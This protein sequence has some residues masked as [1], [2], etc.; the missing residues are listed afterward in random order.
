MA[1][2]RRRSSSSSSS[3]SVVSVLLLLSLVVVVVNAQSL[4]YLSNWSAFFSNSFWSQ[5]T[6]NQGR[7][8]AGGDVTLFNY[9]VGT[10]LNASDCQR[11]DLLVGGDLS[12]RDGSVPN[13]EV[14]VVGQSQ[15]ENV[16][17]ETGCNLASGNSPIDFEAAF[18]ELYGVS[19]NLSQLAPNGESNFYESSLA[20]I[21]TDANKNIFSVPGSQLEGL[22]QIYIS[23]PGGSFAIINVDGDTNTF[24]DLQIYL[25]NTTSYRYILWNFFE[26]KILTLS[27]LSVS[28]SL[29]APAAAIFFN[30]GNIDG[31]IAGYSFNGTGEIHDYPII[32]FCPP[33][34]P[35]HE[36]ITLPDWSIFVE[37]NV[38]LSATDDRGN[39]AAGGNVWLSHYE[40]GVD[41]PDISGQVDLVVGGNL[42]FSSGQIS[43]GNAVVAGTASLYGVGIPSG[44][45]LQN[46]P[47]PIDFGTAFSQLRTLSSSLA[48]IEPNGQVSSGYGNVIGAI[49]NY[50]GLNVFSLSGMVLANATQLNISTPFNSWAI[51]NVDGSADAIEDLQINLSGI[52]PNNVLFN[53][54]ESDQLTLTGVRIEGS[55]LA[56]SADVKFTN[57]AI[58]GSLYVQSLYGDGE[59]HWFPWAPYGPNCK[60]CPPCVN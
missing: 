39:F 54:Y 48:E 29:L 44:S 37:N 18:E 12:F 5:N 57:G 40:I 30:D 32:P 28:G 16:N 20:L 35:C 42:Y 9:E 33:C 7:L 27:G 36:N 45:L 2:S 22:T 3:S 55:I 19:T 26:T 49:G 43:N 21:G 24:A 34:A 51:L 59:V 11:I 52:Q 17:L 4:S 15:I 46:T 50:V 25:A 56:P 23:V 60:P 13:G 53:F 6:D 10:L 1:T 58:D 47:I 41:L 14:L 38:N 31:S 8:A